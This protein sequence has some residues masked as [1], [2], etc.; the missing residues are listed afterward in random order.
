MDD[1]LTPDRVA[2]P[3]SQVIRS[4]SRWRTLRNRFKDHCQRV[5]ARC[6]WCVLRGDSEMATIDY[7]APANSPYAFEADHVQPVDTHPHL[8]YEWANLVPSH[9][10]C[11]RQKGVKTYEQQGEWVKPDW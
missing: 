3:T 9:S 5:G 1:E 2:Y 4:S 6:H 8:A 7:N 10:R 11:N